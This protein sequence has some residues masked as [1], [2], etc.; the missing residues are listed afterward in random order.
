MYGNV[1]SG[2]VPAIKMYIISN[3]NTVGFWWKMVMLVEQKHPAL[4]SFMR[5]M[6]AD[7]A[8]TPTSL[9]MSCPTI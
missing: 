2:F 6:S 9:F 5:S 4:S 1:I 8:G 3:G 7:T